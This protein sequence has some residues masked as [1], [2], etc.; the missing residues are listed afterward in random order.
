MRARTSKDYR[1]F[2]P[3]PTVFVGAAKVTGGKRGA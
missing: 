2:D 1:N 3:L